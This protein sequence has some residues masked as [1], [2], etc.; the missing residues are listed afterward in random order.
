LLK[1]AFVISREIF[2]DKI[3]ISVG[4]IGYSINMVKLE[5]VLDFIE[6]GK[7]KLSNADVSYH[8]GTDNPLDEVIS[9]VA[10]IMNVDLLNEDI[11]I[12]TV[13]SDQQKEQ[14]LH[15]LDQRV[16]NRIPVPYLTNI[17]YFGGRK[18]YI[19]QGAMIPT[20]P[21]AE[22]INNKFKP[23]LL[24]E[25][26]KIL[27]LCTGSGALA[28]SIAKEFPDC[29]I[30]AVDISDR[31]LQVAYKNVKL[32][33]VSSR[34]NIIRSDLFDKISGKYDLILVNPPYVDESE[35][36]NLPKEHTYEPKLAFLA[37]NNGLAIVEKILHQASNFLADDGILFVEVGAYLTAVEEYFDKVPFVWVELYNGGE[38]ILM[39]HKRELESYFN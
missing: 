36:E 7:E 24:H 4:K 18:F 20:S 9:I 10:W 39:M 19:N 34:I 26:T 21:F 16:I 11:D 32:H 6:Y 25:P 27:E 33:D 15:Y 3:C 1:L 17:A 38:G 12:H 31:A 30:D 29:Y 13:L 5:T 2:I 22:L 37:D 14:L 35:Y 8:H 28:I 23:W